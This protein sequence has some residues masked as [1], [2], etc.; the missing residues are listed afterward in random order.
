[1]DY[2]FGRPYDGFVG[3]AWALPTR[4]QTRSRLFCGATVLPFDLKS[5]SKFMTRHSIG[6]FFL[7]ALRM[8]RPRRA[9][10]TTARSECIELPEYPSSLSRPLTMLPQA[11]TARPPDDSSSFM[12]R[13]SGKHDGDGDVDLADL[14]DLLARFGNPC[15]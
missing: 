15:P 10:R 5:E 12:R 3:V 7:P 11:H 9:Q 8:R 1:M 4:T 6:T 13:N 14:T 2:G